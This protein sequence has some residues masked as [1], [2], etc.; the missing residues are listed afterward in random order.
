MVM[1]HVKSLS[2][3]QHLIYSRYNIANKPA[4]LLKR[5]FLFRRLEI[6]VSDGLTDSPI[7]QERKEIKNCQEETVALEN[8]HRFLWWHVVDLKDHFRFV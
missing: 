1:F 8:N 3:L 6:A 2:P 7:I 5:V 4:L